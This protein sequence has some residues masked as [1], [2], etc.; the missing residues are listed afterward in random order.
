MRSRIWLDSN[1]V[2]KIL[3]VIKS[4]HARSSRLFYRYCNNKWFDFRFSPIVFIGLGIT[5]GTFQ[6]FG[7]PI[8]CNNVHK[9]IKSDFLDSYWYCFCTF[10]CCGSVTFWY[11]SGSSDP[12]LCPTYPDADPG[13]PKNIRILRIR[14]QM[15]IWNTGKNS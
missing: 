14:S 11:G 1:P 7:R 6:L 2:A 8:H 3:S 12:Y 13:G 9:H 15:R 10:H 4:A 5:L